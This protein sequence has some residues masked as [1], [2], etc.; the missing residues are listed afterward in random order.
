[1][2]WYYWLLIAV[3]LWI[4]G[5]RV[6]VWWMRHRPEASTYEAEKSEIR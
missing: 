3:G 6:F 5:G 4:T 2:A 1:M